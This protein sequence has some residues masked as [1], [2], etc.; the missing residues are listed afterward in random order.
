MKAQRCHGMT[1]RALKVRVIER[2]QV[3]Q[4]V[5]VEQ[6]VF[7]LRKPRKVLEINGDV[8]KWNT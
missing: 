8:H 5:P 4:R 2:E 6:A 1:Q 3:E 7:P